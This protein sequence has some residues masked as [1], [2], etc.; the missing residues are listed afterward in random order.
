VSRGDFL[1]ENLKLIDTTNNNATLK[2]PPD[3]CILFYHYRGNNWLMDNKDSVRQ[4]EKIIAGLVET[5]PVFKHIRLVCYSYNKD[6]FMNAYNRP[7]FKS[8]QFYSIES[9]YL[10]DKSSPKLLHSDKL[11]LVNK[12]GKVL[13]TSVYIAG[14]KYNHVPETRSLKAKLLTEKNGVKIPVVNAS[15]YLSSATW[16]TL[17]K[18]TTN[19]YGDFELN[20]PDN[21][22]NHSLKVS[23]QDSIKTIILASQEGVELNNLH[24]TKRGFEYKLIQTD[25]IKLS[26]MPEIEDISL[27]FSNFLKTKDKE[28]IRSEHINYNVGSYRIQE[29]SKKILDKVAQILTDNPK[30]KLEVI[31]HTDAQGDDISNMELSEKRS[32]SVVSY[33]ILIG[34]H[35]DRMKY[36]GKGETEIRNRCKNNVDCSDTEHRYNRRTEFKFVKE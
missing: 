18:T 36:I 25:I 5:S 2:M 28:L 30:V 4:V 33:L 13:A 26:D 6:N 32:L 27:A 24:R 14:F 29:E 1:F 35:K 19:K 16:D 22:D 9:Y 21:S 15:V 7:A 23:V 12:K 11:I 3:S 34:V 20:I 10:S 8:N 17:S 31:S